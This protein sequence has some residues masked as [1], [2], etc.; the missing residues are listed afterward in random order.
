MSLTTSV[1][2]LEK[3]IDGDEIS[4]DNFHRMYAPLIRNCGEHWHLT[5]DECDELIQEVMITFFKDAK[6]FKY[7]RN[8]GSFRAHLRSVA[9]DCVFAVL[10]KRKDGGVPLM[11]NPA[12]LDYAFDEKWDAEWYDHICAEALD[13]L[14]DEM[15]KT[16]YRSFYMYVIENRP[17]AEVAAELG[18]SLN[19]VYVNKFRALEHLRRTIRNLNKL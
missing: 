17:P 11:E 18:I 4:W 19:A 5:A 2:L 10:E 16:S 13:V 1:T 12:L 7:D 14:A 9:R 15:E 6:S 8:S 3:I